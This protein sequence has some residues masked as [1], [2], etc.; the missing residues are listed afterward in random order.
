LRTRSVPHRS[1][2][3]NDWLDNWNTSLA[4]DL[5]ALWL[6]RRS[7]SSL[8]CSLTTTSSHDFA[9]RKLDLRQHLPMIANTDRSRAYE[10]K[11]QKPFRKGR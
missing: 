6:D 2:S 10:K 9:C 11:A 3:G 8:C 1:I 5:G 4:L 7:G